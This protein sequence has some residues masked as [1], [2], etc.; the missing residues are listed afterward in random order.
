[1]KNQTHLTIYTTG[2][3]ADIRYKGRTK[4]SSLDVTIYFD[5]YEVM[6]YIG[7]THRVKFY[8][9]EVVVASVDTN[10][11]NTLEVGFGE[12]TKVRIQQDPYHYVSPSQKEQIET[13][14]LTLRQAI[15]TNNPTLA[16]FC[17]DNG[18]F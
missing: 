11:K 8:L 14:S 6:G 13:G 16:Q 9:N 15:E 10:I 12:L 4:D 3:N 2:K 5:R 1:M 7:D 17:R 18:I